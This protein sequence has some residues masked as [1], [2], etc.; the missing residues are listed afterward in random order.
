MKKILKII[1]INIIGL[2][3]LGLFD[4]YNII[5]VPPTHYIIGYGMGILTFILIKK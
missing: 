1:T 3:I 4:N 5:N 2:T